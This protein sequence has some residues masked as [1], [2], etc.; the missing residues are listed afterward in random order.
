MFSF[1]LTYNR[2]YNYEAGTFVLCCFVYQS[3]NVVYTNFIRSRGLLE[4]E[5][6]NSR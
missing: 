2:V 4:I 5:V 6:Q 3:L 1:I